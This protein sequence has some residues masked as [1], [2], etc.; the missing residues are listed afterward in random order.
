MNA[1]KRT[2]LSHDDAV[3]VTFRIADRLEMSYE[4]IAPLILEAFRG[5][6]WRALDYTSWQAYCEAEFTGPRMLRLPD[7]IIDELAGE[8]M[9][10]RS[11]A[12]ALGRSKS[13]VD[14]KMNK[15]ARP[16][17]IVSSDGKRRPAR[18]ES[19]SR[20]AHP[21]GKASV[22]KGMPAWEVVLCYVTDETPVSTWVDIV[23]G[24]GWRDSKVTGA[25]SECS[26]R[27]VITSAGERDG[28]TVWVPVP[29]IT[30]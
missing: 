27:G 13:D 3:F 12:H 25:L 8:G 30:E 4:G 21:A 9:S 20:R 17:R 6:A 28:N 1:R 24:L 11:I 7:S 18:S 16:L 29:E 15:S 5:L 10:S 14:R 26:R 2:A 22:M 23:D 19:Q